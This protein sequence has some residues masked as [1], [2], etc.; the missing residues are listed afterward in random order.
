M[1]GL[2]VSYMFTKTIRPSGGDKHLNGGPRTFSFCFWLCTTALVLGG[3][4]YER[5]PGLPSATKISARVGYGGVE[6][7]GLLVLGLGVAIQTDTEKASGK[8]VPDGNVGWAQDRD[9]VGRKGRANRWRPQR[10]QAVVG[11]R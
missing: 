2:L 9:A 8:Q 5:S 4:C 3:M 1:A 7:S 6:R 10:T 11:R